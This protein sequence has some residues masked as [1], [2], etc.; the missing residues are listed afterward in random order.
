MKRVGQVTLAANITRLILP[1]YD[2]LEDFGTPP[3]DG[4]HQN[5]KLELPTEAFGFETVDGGHSGPW[6][7]AEAVYPQE[8]HNDGPSTRISPGGIKGTQ[9]AH[10]RQV[11][12]KKN[13]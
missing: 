3:P 2:G 12:E 9:Q 13:D 7:W 4:Q 1:S 6:G 11:G 5:D 10:G 8:E